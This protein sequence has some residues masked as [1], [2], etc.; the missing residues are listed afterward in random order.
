MLK[1]ASITI[2]LLGLSV[3]LGIWVGSNYL[4]DSHT[5]DHTAAKVNTS[6]LEEEMYFVDLIVRGT[7]VEQQDPVVRNAG[8]PEKVNFSYDVT[9]S[10]IKVNEVI[11]GEL[12]EK[13]ITFLQHGTEKTN[14]ETRYLKTEEEVILLLMK[15]VDNYYWSY[16]YEEG[17]WRVNDGLIESKNNNIS[18]FLATD[19][20]ISKFRNSGNQDVESFVK[21]I[22]KAALNKKRPEF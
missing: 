15:A 8:L 7:V 21:E 4:S 20:A 14:E 18:G 1:R 11:Y 6:S 19:T 2:L 12:E 5:E 16:N 17:I 3:F 10:I 9:P 22:K 13:T